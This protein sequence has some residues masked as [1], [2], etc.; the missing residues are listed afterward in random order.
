MLNSNYL[1]TTVSALDSCFLQ[2]PLNGNNILNHEQN[3]IY[4]LE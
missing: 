4:T 3:W 1:I 2:T